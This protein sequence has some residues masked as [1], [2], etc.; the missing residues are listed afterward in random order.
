MFEALYHPFILVCGLPLPRA[1]SVLVDSVETHAHFPG[2][3]VS[4]DVAEVDYG[5]ELGPRVY[6]SAATA[7][8]ARERMEAF[9]VLSGV[10]C[11]KLGPDKVCAQFSV[12]PVPVG[13]VCGD[14]IFGALFFGPFLGFHEK[15][16]AVFEVNVVFWMRL[17]GGG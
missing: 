9:G 13:G 6:V 14:E 1:S 10:V 15:S 4:H 16:V 12:F 8:I 11:L 17:T 5:S 3:A 2:T 7:V